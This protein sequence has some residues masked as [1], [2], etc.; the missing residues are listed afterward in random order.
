MA[1]LPYIATYELA[2]LAVSQYEPRLALDGGADGLDLIRRLLADVPQVCPRG[3]LILLE[4]GADQGAAT[5]EL[6][7]ST[8][9]PE[10][11]EVL[12]DYAGLD[13]IVRVIL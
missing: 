5:L 4:I 1:I 9:Q 10:S 2:A 11:A 6:A 7:R 13:R 8:L 12:Q 3:A